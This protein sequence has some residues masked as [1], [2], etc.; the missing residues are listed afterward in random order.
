[1]VARLEVVEVFGA[2]GGRRRR[3]LPALFL[4][5]VEVARVAL[6]AYLGHNGR[7][8]F[9]LHERL[10]V[11]ALEPA[12]RFDVLGSVLHG[13]EAAR[14]VDDEQP[15]DEV[16]RR[17][18]HVARHLHLASQYLLVDL[19]RVVVEKWLCKTNKQTN[20]RIN[21]EIIYKYTK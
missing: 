12:V 5:L 16:A 18:H 14:L 10:P 20:K 7:R 21:N 19:E 2:L 15:L 8:Q 17:A 9:A 1:M 13:A 6:V 3:G 4:V 11:D